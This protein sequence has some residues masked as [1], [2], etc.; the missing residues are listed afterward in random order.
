MPVIVDVDADALWLDASASADALRALFV[1][2]TSERMEAV[3]VGPW[4]SNA[5]NEGPPCWRRTLEVTRTNNEGT[6]RLKCAASELGAEQLR[7]KR[8]TAEQVERRRR[9]ARELD[10]GIA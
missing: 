10:L 3:P 4:V 9:T 6:Q 7:G 5:R 2:Y 8:L 1:P